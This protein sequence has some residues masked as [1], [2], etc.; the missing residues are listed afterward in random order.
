MGER[1][2]PGAPPQGQNPAQSDVPIPGGSCGYAWCSDMHLL[3]AAEHHKHE[4]CHSLCLLVDHSRHCRYEPDAADSGLDN[5]GQHHFVHKFP[6]LGFRGLDSAVLGR[7]RDWKG[8]TKKCCSPNF[9]PILPLLVHLCWPPSGTRPIARV[10]GCA[11][12]WPQ[13]NVSTA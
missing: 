1:Y 3:S 4:V 9:M 7:Y 6:E 8:L 5:A 11:R 13:R 10:Q 12:S 2:H